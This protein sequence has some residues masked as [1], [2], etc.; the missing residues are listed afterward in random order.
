[1][2]DVPNESGSKFNTP[3][4]ADSVG[5]EGSSP[6]RA[7]RPLAMFLDRSLRRSFE[8]WGSFRGG[9]GE[10]QGGQ[11]RPSFSSLASL[12]FYERA[13]LTKVP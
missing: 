12:F 9:E 1:M 4:A 3:P 5:E 7:T 6:K 13:R 2:E 11:L 10:G 8:I